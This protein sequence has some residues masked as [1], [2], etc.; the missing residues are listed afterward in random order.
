MEQSNTKMYSLLAL[1][2]NYQNPHAQYAQLR[3]HDSIYFD[4]SSQCWLVTGHA[5]ATTILDDQR[6]TSQLGTDSASTVASVNKQMLFMD[7]D[8]HQQIQNVMLRPLASMAK[9]IPDEIRSFVHGIVMD[10]QARG[11]IDLVQ[12]FAAKISLFGI[13]RILGIPL[14][15]WDHLLRLERWSDT[16][17]DLT[18]GYVRGDKQ[19][20]TNLEIYFAQLIAM[21]RLQPADDLLSSLI[22]DE[23][24]FPKEDD[25][26]ANCMMIFAAGR[27]TSKK[28]LGNG[29]PLLLQDWQSQRKEYQNNPKIFPRMLGEELLRMVTPTRYLMRQANED[30][31]FPHQHVIHKGDRL[32]VFLEA[33]N[34]DPAFFEDP[35]TFS[36]Q[37][38]PNK[39][40]A[41]GFGSHQCPGATLAR[42][43]IQVALEELLSLSELR[44]KPGSHP[45]W[46]PNP[47]LGGYISCPALF[48]L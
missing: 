38:R 26:V 28:V 22:E 11:E 31:D 36:P 40:L 20:V 37:R 1:R 27:V 18:S 43:E 34:R 24:A 35:D 2:R 48:R 16:L 10:W 42:I 13:A 32:L 17:G 47:N 44:L 12:D 39:H 21:K 7:G 9:K 15:D 46:N 33:A 5:L 25:L 29:I 45:R 30:V 6:F 19:D 4:P 41:F 14:D 3:V 23:E 8:R